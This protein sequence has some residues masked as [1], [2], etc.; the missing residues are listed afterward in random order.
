MEDYIIN[1]RQYDLHKKI[2]LKTKESY[3]SV[4]KMYSKHRSVTICKNMQVTISEYGDVIHFKCNEC[5]YDF[6]NDY[7][8]MCEQ[9]K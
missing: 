8:K 6:M 5:G 3:D 2:M 4:L 7:N 1:K 9:V